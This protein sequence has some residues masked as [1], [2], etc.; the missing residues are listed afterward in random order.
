MLPVALVGFGWWGRT[1]A[2]RLKENSLF[3]SNTRRD[4]KLPIAV[5]PPGKNKRNGAHNKN[6]RTGGHKKRRN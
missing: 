1:I 5:D 2:S 4:F 3:E 6:R